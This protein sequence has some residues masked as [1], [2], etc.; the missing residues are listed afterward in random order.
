MSPTN[1]GP[2]PSPEAPIT[3]RPLSTADRGRHGHIGDRAGVDVEDDLAVGAHRGDADPPLRREGVAR[4]GVGPDGRSERIDAQP[5]ETQQA[6]VVHAEAVA[7]GR[8]AGAE[9][10][11]HRAGRP[12]PTD[13]RLEGEGV[14]LA[15]RQR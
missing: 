5:A 6:V 8:V 12:A 3:K 14:V 4:G 11:D 7:A 1:P 10:V 2:S 9:A 13:G 15:E